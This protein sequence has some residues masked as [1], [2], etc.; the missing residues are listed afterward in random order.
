[1]KRGCPCR[2]S[3]DWRTCCG[4][5]RWSGRSGASS[6]STRRSG[7][8]SCGR[9]GSLPKRR[10]AARA[11]SSA[12]HCCRPSGRGTWTSAIWAD[13][14]ARNLR[15]AARR[16]GHAPGFALTVIATLALGI[17]A[18]T[19]VFSALDAVLLRP[20]PFPRGRSPGAADAEADREL[21]DL[22]RA[23]AARG[24]E[25]A[26]LHVPRDQRLLRR[27]RVRDVRGSAGARPAR[28]RHAAHARG[29]RSLPCAGARLQGRR[30]PLRRSARRPDQR[31]LLARAAGVEPRRAV[32]QRPHRWR[33]GADRG[34][35][36][37]VLP[38]S[39][40]G[41]GPLVPVARGRAV[42]PVAAEHLVP[43]RRPAARGGDAGPGARRPH[44]RAGT[45]G[46]AVPRPRPEDRRRARAAQGAGG[47]RRGAFA[48]APVRRGERPAADRVHQ[49]RGALPRARRLAPSGDR[50]AHVA[51]RL[52]DRRSPG[53]S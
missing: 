40:S 7:P 36:A 39:R 38:L 34:S 53:W 49:H 42:R 50:A 52:A 18:N 9:R 24:L 26:Q 37:R 45:A 47:E 25:P 16:L 11:C 51:R 13:G 15:H 5:G 21:R 30:A 28:V 3:R 1:M 23:G 17:G 6:S 46:R 41:G 14:V 2:G 12:T 32:S 19:A 31:S 33:S 20:L 44:R 4:P 29:L 10:R 43:G 27:G 35:D 8:T 22:D 48:V